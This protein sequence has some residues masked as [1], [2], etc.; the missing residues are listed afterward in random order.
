MRTVLTIAGSDPSGGAGIQAD[1]KTFHALGMFGLSV[2]T[3]VTVQNTQKVYN[4]QE[5]QPEIVAGQIMCLFDDIEISAVKIGMVSSL[6]LVN[7][8]ADVLKKVDLPH[9]IL[10]PVMISTSGYRLLEKEACEALVT[11]LFPLAD[12][13]TPNIPEAE[14]ITGKQIKSMAD[15]KDAAPELL[16]SGAKKV[17]V[18]G[19]HLKGEVAAD[20]AYDGTTY[21]EYQSARIKTRNTHGTGCTFSSAIAA[22]MAAGN[23]FFQSVADAKKYINEAILH[24]LSIGKGPGPVNHF[25]G[26]A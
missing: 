3:A 22:G 25:F 13:I 16:L 15:M 20:V 10:D 26:M 2:I 21:Q 23:D 6:R 1:I 9:L 14:A 8:I 7:V 4:V 19:G 11:T 18:K 5:V 12:V 24:S 17:V